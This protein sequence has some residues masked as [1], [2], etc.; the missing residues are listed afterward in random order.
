MTSET[1]EAK[2]EGYDDHVVIVTGV[3]APPRCP[4]TD[5]G[6]GRCGGRATTLVQVGD[7]LG[8]GAYLRVCVYHADLIDDCEEMSDE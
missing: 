7:R 1:H 5:E 3:Y 6:T 4:V 8:V 2:Y